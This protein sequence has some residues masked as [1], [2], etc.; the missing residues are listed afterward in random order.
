MLAANLV[1]C[2]IL[3]GG[4]AWAQS[5]FPLLREQAVQTG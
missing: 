5:R 4:F 1:F 3:F 2:A